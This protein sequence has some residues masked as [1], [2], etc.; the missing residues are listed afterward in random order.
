KL[1]KAS[2]SGST[3]IP[4]TI[5][6]NRNKK[7]RNTAD[8]L[9]FSKAAGMS[10]SDQLIYLKLWDHTNSKTKW[11]EFAQNI[12]PHNIMDSSDQ[13]IASLISKIEQSK[14]TKSILGYPS[15][16]EQICKYLDAQ[17]Y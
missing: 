14:S 16:F 7:N 11:Q 15:F 13:D 12:L 6:Q 3:G 4:F 9:Y 5:F 10:I 1:N 8:T 17:N 2:S